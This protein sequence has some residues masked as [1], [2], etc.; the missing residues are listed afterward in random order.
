MGMVERVELD[1]CGVT[2][3]WMKES[4]GAE[5]LGDGDYHWIGKERRRQ[6][7]W[8]GDGGVGILVRKR[9]GTPQR[10]E[11]GAED[12][13][14]L[15]IK[16]DLGRRIYIGVV[17]VPPKGSR[18]GIT[19]EEALVVVE[20]D[21]S[22]FRSDGEVVLLGDWNRRIGQL[23]SRAG[24]KVFERK[25]QDRK[26]GQGGRELID[27]MEGL[28]LVVMN[29][30]DGGGEFTFRSTGGTSVIDY[31]MMGVRCGEGGGR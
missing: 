19:L 14:V 25:S 16:L 6:K 1:I 26:V 2:E 12:L 24:G 29:G 27:S 15:W 4:R 21:V 10:V 23:P 31:V 7:S 5:G 11:G 18:T 13:D 28:D 20:R 3:T 17:Y 8:S 22:R 9:L 30:C